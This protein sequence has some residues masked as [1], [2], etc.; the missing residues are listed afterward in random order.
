MSEVS[1][2]Q[3]DDIQDAI[4][5]FGLVDA[6]HTVYP[7]VTQQA[8]P[9]I[10]AQDVLAEIACDRHVNETVARFRDNPVAF[11]KGG[12]MVDVGLI[13]P[14][15]FSIIIAALESVASTAHAMDQMMESQL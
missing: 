13:D 15:S 7:C 6:A 3:L 11:I 5:T 14:K 12:E 8:G 1:T 10:G 9:A 2:R 4:D